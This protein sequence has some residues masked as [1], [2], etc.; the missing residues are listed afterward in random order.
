MKLIP[1]RIPDVVIVEPAVFGDDRG[2]FM[3][4]FNQQRFNAELAKLGLP[5]PRP[6]VQDNHSCSKKG[7]LRGL[8]YQ[9]PPSAQGK[10]VR[11]VQGA[12]FDVA[13][14]IRR[15]SPTFGQWAGV[16]LSAQNNRQLWVP[17]G[18]AHG[19]LALADDTHFLYKTT[20]VYAKDCERAI[21]WDDPDIGIDWPLAGLTPGL[22]A[23]DA[24]APRLKDAD[25][26]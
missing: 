25:Y 8:H 23:K 11:V 22:A 12:A 21:V 19:F 24:Q 13:V 18:F 1:T 10:L 2:W 15:G 7:V 26:F 3:E 17:E 16:E 5:A 14:D 20:D 6:F 4:S 9:L